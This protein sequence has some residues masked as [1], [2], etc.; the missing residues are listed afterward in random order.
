MQSGHPNRQA[1]YK[2]DGMMEE[3]FT[4]F[5]F[6]SPLPMHERVPDFPHCGRCT[7]AFILENG[8]QRPGGD[9]APG[10]G[11]HIVVA[12]DAVAST[13]AGLNNLVQMHRDGH[14]DAEEFRAAKRRM[15]HMH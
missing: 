15:L 10:A 8:K 4:T 2:L 1:A 14:L 5:R 13:A 7:A 9:V 12:P 6:F 11:R 3:R